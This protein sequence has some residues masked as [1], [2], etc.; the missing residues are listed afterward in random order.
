MIKSRTVI[1][2]SAVFLSAALAASFFLTSRTP[3]PTPTPTPT[4]SAVVIPADLK[5]SDVLTWD[6]ETSEFKPE[7][8]MLTCADGGWL[9]YKIKWKTWTKEKA[10]GTGYF[11]ENLCNPSC[12]EGKR[13]EAPVNVTLTD[14]TP[15]KGKYYL[16][17]LDIRTSDGKDFPWG[18]A[19]VL[20]W[21]VMEFAEQMNW[22]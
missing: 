16:R 21:D 1:A 20:G 14:L 6:C 22:D 17:S 3:E 15:Y 7:T 2:A 8:I 10:T 5:D 11:S 18:K 4:E 12:A 13:V 9:V 19:G